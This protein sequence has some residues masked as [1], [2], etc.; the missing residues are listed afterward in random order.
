MNEDL[1][2]R[3]G[4]SVYDPAEKRLAEL[5]QWEI[6]LAYRRKT[7]ADPVNVEKISHTI[8]EIED[9]IAITKIEVE[10]EKTASGRRDKKRQNVKRRTSSAFT[11]V[12][13]SL[14]SLLGVVIYLFGFLYLLVDQHPTLRDPGQYLHFLPD[15]SE[16]LVLPI[17][18][19]WDN[20]N[21]II[22]YGPDGRLGLELIV[23]GIIIYM[24]YIDRPGSVEFFFPAMIM[25]IVFTLFHWSRNGIEGRF[26]F[27]GAL[28]QGFVLFLCFI[29]G[30]LLGV[31]AL[32]IL[33]C[34]FDRDQDPE[35]E[36]NQNQ[37]S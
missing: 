12:V 8:Q 32:G 14:P 31:V 29:V 20:V 26:A 37:N 35:Q 6:S 4:I 24:I 23:L 25:T 7:E 27:E 19:I 34:I 18:F 1:L 5:D 9:E 13:R 15:I 22:Y 10:K 36:K 11:A 30:F 2:K 16:W 28:R 33:G 3:L 21:K 17:H